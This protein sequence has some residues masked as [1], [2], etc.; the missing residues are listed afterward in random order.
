M[1]GTPRNII[2]YNRNNVPLDG[3][4]GSAFTHVILAVV[5]P[6]VSGGIDTAVIDK[7]L[8][9][10]G[11]V[12]KLKENGKRKVLF[13]LGGD[14]DYIPAGAWKS[15]SLNVSSFAKSLVDYAVKHDFDGIDIDFED[16]ASLQNPAAASYDAKKFLIALSKE[17]K[18]AVPPGKSLIVTHAPQAPYFDP[19]WKEAPYSQIASAAGDAIDWFNIQYYNNGTWYNG[20]TNDGP[21]QKEKITGLS[22]STPP[23][24][25]ILALSEQAAT[26]VEKLVL[27]RVTSL[28]NAGLN[29]TMAGYL[30]AADTV[31][32]LVQPLMSHFGAKFGGVMAWQYSLHVSSTETA[33]SWGKTIQGALEQALADA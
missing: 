29:K 10:P 13:A 24:W 27:G 19:A 16:T 20:N 33:N 7:F 4:V 17:L 12:P 31:T 25:S 26:P 3:I 6:T 15:A 11:V 22:G 28:D 2:Y 1:A 23:G 9:E 5:V 21:A 30:S 8:S 32:Y 18:A 14:E